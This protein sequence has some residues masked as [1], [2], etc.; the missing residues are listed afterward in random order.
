MVNIPGYIRLGVEHNF[1]ALSNIGQ[2]L[3]NH[4]AHELGQVSHQT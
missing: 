1:L 3:R 4:S 2:Q